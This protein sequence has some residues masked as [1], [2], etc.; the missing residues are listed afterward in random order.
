MEIAV[1]VL[2]LLLVGLGVWYSYYRKQQRRQGLA[3][4]ASQYGLVFS[5]EDPFGL[6]GY[7]FRLFSRG[8]GRGCENVVY[9]EWKGIPIR[10]AD[11]W[12]YD[13]TTDSQGR[14]SKSYHRF[15][16]V[17]ADVGIDTPPVSIAKE[18]LLSRIADHVGLHDIEFESEQFNRVFQVKAGD[19][20]F[21]FKLV[22]ARMIHWLL[23][24]EGTFGFEVT[25]PWLL[26]HRSRLRPTELIP[27]IGTAKAFG[28]HIPQLVRTEYPGS[29]A[30]RA[31]KGA[32]P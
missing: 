25:G 2:A 8:D 7:P 12:Y 11:Y 22:D 32:E 5:P 27:L 15:S 24:T 6:I 30:T 31:Q 26:V 20:E 4:F 9:G 29:S 14:R 1:V 3:A 13:E 17:I 18:S 28:D 19:R 21:C 23:A 10:E 16:V